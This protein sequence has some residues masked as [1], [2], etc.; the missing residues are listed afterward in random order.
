MILIQKSDFILTER[1]RIYALNEIIEY[2]A[3]ILIRE[4]LNSIY[5]YFINEYKIKQI[6]M[7]YIFQLDIIS[8]SKKEKLRVRIYPKKLIILNLFYS[9]FDWD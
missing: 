9:I 7:R 1:S 8:P 4:M 2:S 6:T 3:E 5:A